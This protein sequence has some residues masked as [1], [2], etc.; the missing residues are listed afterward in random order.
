MS[1][2]IKNITVTAAHDAAQAGRVLLVDVRTP[3]EWEQTGVAVS[4]HT[5]DMQS[6]TFYQDIIALHNTNPE[7]PIAF[8]CRTGHRSMLT[9]RE[10][11]SRDMAVF[12]VVGG[13]AGTS[14]DSG[15]I[16]CALPLKTVTTQS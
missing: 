8:I 6:A 10:C 12:N 5:F 1:D 4:A 14:K 13:M 7:M 3:T 15:W 11:A 16:D 9:A 2:V